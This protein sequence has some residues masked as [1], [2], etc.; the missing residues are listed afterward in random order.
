MIAPLLTAAWLGILTAVS[1]CPLATNVAAV[2]F[3]GRHAARPRRALFAGIFYV[4]GRTVCY[5]ALAA[6]LA[7]GL[8]A[9]VQTSGV[10]SRIVVLLLGPALIVAGVLMAEL[11]PMPSFGGSS[12]GL[13]ERLG[14][15]GDFVGAMLLGGV[16]A[17]SFCPSSAAIFFGALLP[18][19]TQSDSIVL[20]PVTYGIA[21]GAP[22]LL[23]ALLLAGGSQRIG[24]I[25]Q[26]TQQVEYW[27]R[28][29]TAYT[30]IGI[31]VYLTLKTNLAL[32]WLA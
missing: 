12:A 18:L 19:A 9:V 31:G 7:Y 32:S 28:R 26:R 15:R 14:K 27:L 21:T 29:L 30:L 3:L 23:F 6:L 1:P 8:L 17:M 5:T 2:G 20:V 11:L 22:V 10:L 13:V 24:S 4:L 16:F 25:F